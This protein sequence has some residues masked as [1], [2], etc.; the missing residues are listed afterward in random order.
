MND[1]MPCVGGRTER[2]GRAAVTRAE[3][4]GGAAMMGAGPVIGVGHIGVWE[5]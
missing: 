2:A 1:S 3:E 4:R 5:L